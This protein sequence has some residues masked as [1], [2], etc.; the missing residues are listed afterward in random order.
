[1]FEDFNELTVWDVL[2]F[3]GCLIGLG[4]FVLTVA[5]WSIIIVGG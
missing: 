1:M 4:F 2:E 5:V 3:T